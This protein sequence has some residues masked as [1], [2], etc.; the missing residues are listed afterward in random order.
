MVWFRGESNSDLNSNARAEAERIV[1]RYWP[2]NPTDEKL[3]SHIAKLL[4]DAVESMYP[5]ENLSALLASSSARRRNGSSET[6]R[7]SAKSASPATT[8]S[9]PLS[10]SDA[11]D[12]IHN[13]VSKLQSLPIAHKR[14]SN[15]EPTAVSPASSVQKSPSSDGQIT[16]KISRSRGDTQTLRLD[17]EITMHA[18]QNKIQE[19]FNIAPDQQ[20]LK[21]G[22]PPK[23]LQAPGN[24][25]PLG[26]K[27]GDK[28]TVSENRLSDTS[29]NQ[30][31]D[32]AE[33]ETTTAVNF[34][35]LDSLHRRFLRGFRESGCSVKWEY[36]MKKPEEFY[37]GGY[38]Y[39]KFKE[40]IGLEDSRHCRLPLLEH[41]S[42]CY[43]KKH[44]RVEACFEPYM[45]HC[46]I[47]D[48]IQKQY[49]KYLARCGGK[50][51]HPSTR[52]NLKLSP[53]PSSGAGK[54]STLAPGYLTLGDSPA[55]PSEHEKTATRDELFELL[56]KSKKST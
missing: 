25:L 16:V 38:I 54:S 53:L 49:E 14:K 18:L 31:V 52:L 5:S 10:T 37:P 21:H 51:Q 50:I 7:R 12:A 34:N 55:L 19:L 8:S 40:D 27:S 30:T 44:N 13:V 15:G 20:I 4:D 35:S 47:N 22:F 42:F 48:D 6:Y 45:G 46:P 1:S 29:L 36:A 33:T 41:P 9:L 2:N 26:L 3:I 32:V 56:S 28:I 11:N 24:G 23:P 17:P 43:N 39:E